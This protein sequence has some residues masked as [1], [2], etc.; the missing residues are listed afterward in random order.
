VSAGFGFGNNYKADVLDLTIAAF[1]AR[2][3][4]LSV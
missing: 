3:I 1:A 2:L 4:G